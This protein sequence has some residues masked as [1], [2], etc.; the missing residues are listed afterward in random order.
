MIS[1]RKKSDYSNF[2]VPKHVAII[3]DGNRRWAKKNKKSI[4]RGH[5][6]GVISVQKAIRY[7]L[8]NNITSLTLFAFSKENWSRSKREISSLVRLFSFFLGKNLSE[9]FITH[10]IK[11]FIIGEIDQFGNSIKKKVQKIVDSTRNNVKLNLNIAINYSGR[12]DILNSVR[13]IIREVQ[14]GSILMEN[15]REHTIDQF[16]CLHDQPEVD[17]VIRTGREH[18][19]SNFLLWQIAYSELYFTDI[20]WPDFNEDIFQ[21]AILNFNTRERRFGNANAIKER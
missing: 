17:L 8:K 2:D 12:W 10:D 14:D 18:R 9:K 11:L 13:K 5:L 3:M 4:I 1:I 7:A 15:I 20:L 21:K 6:A 16:I 19:I